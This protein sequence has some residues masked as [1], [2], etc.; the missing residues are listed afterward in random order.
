MCVYVRE[1][2]SKKKSNN[3]A[4]KLKITFLGQLTTGRCGQVLEK[5]AQALAGKPDL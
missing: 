2:E 4:D 3:R 1:R 5:T